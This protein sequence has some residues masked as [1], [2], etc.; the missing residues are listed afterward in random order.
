MNDKLKQVSKEYGQS[1]YNILHYGSTPAVLF[2]EDL[3]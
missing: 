1:N 2:S 3:Y